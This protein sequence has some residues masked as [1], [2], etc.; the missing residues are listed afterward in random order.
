MRRPVN[1]SIPIVFD[2]WT[3]LEIAVRRHLKSAGRGLRGVSEMLE[4]RLR[5]AP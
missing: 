3:D 5:G 4:R 1:L 2:S